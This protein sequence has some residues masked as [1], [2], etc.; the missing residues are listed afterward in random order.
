MNYSIVKV[1]GKERYDVQ[2]DGEIATGKIVELKFPDDMIS[3]Q[4]K[5]LGF[6][7]K[8]PNYSEITPDSWIV[9]DDLS[10]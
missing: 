3:K 1:G 6:S 2:Y 5:V 9:T 8:W 4:Y 7:G 10:A